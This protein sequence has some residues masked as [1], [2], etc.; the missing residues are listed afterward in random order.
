M[1]LKGVEV[2]S[3]FENEWLKLGTLG[4]LLQY[5]LKEVIG[6]SAFPSRISPIWPISTIDMTDTNMTDM[7]DTDMTDIDNQHY[8][9]QYY[10][11]YQ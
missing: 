7:T 1:W 6:Y 10:D 8:W 2:S 4:K 5:I 9:Y 3:K 11:R